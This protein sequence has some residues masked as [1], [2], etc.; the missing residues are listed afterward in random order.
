MTKDPRQTLSSLVDGEYPPRELREAVPSM[1]EDN[2][3]R[4]LW[5]RYHLIGQAIRGETL[6]G[7]ARGVADALA[8]R[9][10]GAGE[11]AP[12][13]T[14]HPLPGRAERERSRKT[15]QARLLPPVA[16]ALAAAMALLAVFVMPL[17]PADRPGQVADRGGPSPAIV[18]DAPG[19]SRWQNTSPVLRAKLDQMLV[20]HHERVPSPRMPGYISYAA[21]VGHEAGR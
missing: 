12:P 6:R 7:G 20:S 9:F 21:V 2:E 3:L 14:V 18:V 17:G 11:P 15:P 5:E 13:A 8:D 4:A 19:E 16:A 10:A 1:L